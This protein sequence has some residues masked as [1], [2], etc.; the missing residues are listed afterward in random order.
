MNNNNYITDDLIANFDITNNLIT[1]NPNNE[2]DII[3]N[4]INL[5]LNN[6]KHN[7]SYINGNVNGNV[8]GTGNSGRG[9]NVN[10][11]NNYRSDRLVTDTTIKTNSNTEKFLDYYS[12]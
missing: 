2:N 3:M 12:I 11:Y 6:Y 9:H 7:N 8:N 1:N 5:I 10:V 4:Y